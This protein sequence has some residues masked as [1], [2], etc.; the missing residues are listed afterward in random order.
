M[1]L[2]IDL[3]NKSIL[4]INFL[5]VIRLILVVDKIKKIKYNKTIN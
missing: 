2:R 1:K 3:F 4:F 5:D